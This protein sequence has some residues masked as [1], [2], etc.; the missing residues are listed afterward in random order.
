V[1][2][3]SGLLGVRSE[4]GHRVFLHHGSLVM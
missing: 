4:R 3:L 1:G 2:V